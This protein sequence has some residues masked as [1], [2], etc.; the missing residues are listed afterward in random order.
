MGFGSLLA[1]LGIGAGADVAGGAVNTGL[2]YLANKSLQEQDQAFQHMEASAARNWQAEQA[3]INRDW[4]TNANQI[5]MD[6]SSRE[7]AAQRA[8]EQEMSSTAHQR[9]MADLKAAGLNP[10]LTATGG[11]GAD[12]VSGASASGVAASPSS[13]GGATSARGSSAHVN[14]KMDFKALTDFV[15]D[16][17]KSARE[18][19]RR[20]DE[21]EHEKAMQE[22]RQHHEKLMEERKIQGALRVE[23]FRRD[24]DHRSYRYDD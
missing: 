20:S 19:A 6:F 2:N 23:D 13:G 17:M 5:A 4:Q 18:I 9:E 16:Y 15:G 24:N 10:I 14:S 3:Q 11:M 22:M 21:F 7:A 1:L 8:W 12:T